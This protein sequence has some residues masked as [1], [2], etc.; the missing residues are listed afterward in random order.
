MSTLGDELLR[1]WPNLEGSQAAGESSPEKRLLGLLSAARRELLNEQPAEPH[2]VLARLNCPVYI[3][4]NPDNLLVDA[5][6]DEGKHPREEACDWRKTLGKSPAAFE[7]DDYLPS[8]EEP[9]VC[10]LLGHLSSWKS[11][12]V[13]EDDYLDCVIGL[14]RL[15]TRPQP[16]QWQAKLADSGLLMLGFRLNEWDF[17]VVNH[18]LQSLEG[19]KL[20]EELYK[21]VAVQVEPEEGMGAN[22]DEV[23]R[24][25]EKYFAG[26][27][28]E[29]YWGSVED[30]ARELNQRWPP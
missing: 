8:V 4:M 2:R 15:Q 28:T 26:S 18:F 24:Y 20:G 10:Q 27:R 29:T 16:S 6:R 30:F 1:R 17:R 9:L 13:S 14:T 19:R 21:N 12:V 22:L 23:R 7:Q 5:L 25:L 3:T 11:V